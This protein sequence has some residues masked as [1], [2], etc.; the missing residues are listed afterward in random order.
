MRQLNLQ[1][2]KQDKNYFHYR[3]ADVIYQS[4]IELTDLEF[5]IQAPVSIKPTNSINHSVDNIIYQQK[6][7]IG[8]QHYAIQLSTDNKDCYQLTHQTQI[9]YIN[10]TDIRAQLKHIDITLLM[11]PVIILNLVLNKVYCLH[12]SAFTINHKTFVLMANSGTGKSTIARY[13]GQQA[14]SKRLA[15]DI[16][17]VKINNNGLQ[18]LPCFPQLKLTQAQQNKPNAT[19][20]SVILLFAQKSND[21]TIKVIDSFNSIKKLINHTVAT[22]LFNNKDLKA[23]LDFCYLTC[24]QN[25]CLQVNYQHSPDSLSKLYQQ[26]YAL[27]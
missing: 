20:G 2:L 6:V 23:H 16:L 22:K 7:L 4:D 3:I 19:S 27:T 8:E 12:A 5:L 9:Y 13:M 15:D 25:Q 18:V 11:G 17:P 10:K 1:T 21:T 24:Q 26:L 14:N